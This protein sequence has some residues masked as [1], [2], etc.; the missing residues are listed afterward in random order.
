MT[1]SWSRT[2]LAFVAGSLISGVGFLT[3]WNPDILNTKAFEFLLIPFSALFMLGLIFSG[4]LGGNFHDPSLVLATAVNALVFFIVLRFVI[5][6]VWKDR[7]HN[8][9]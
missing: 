8:G 6:K 9:A 4:I 1:R 7:N 5:N 2:V 3:Y